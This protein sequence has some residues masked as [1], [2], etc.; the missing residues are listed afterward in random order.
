MKALLSIALT[1]GLG[2]P[3]MAETQAPKLVVAIVV[4]QFSPEL[5][6][7]AHQQAL[8]GNARAI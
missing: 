3:A 1:I 8:T 4:D 6:P 2:G 7:N 5:S